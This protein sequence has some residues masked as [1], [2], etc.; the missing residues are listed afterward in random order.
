MDRK[1]LRIIGYVMIFCGLS[2]LLLFA[3]RKISRE[4]Y[5]RKLLRENIV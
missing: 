4:L 5:L 1:K 3:Y 2:V